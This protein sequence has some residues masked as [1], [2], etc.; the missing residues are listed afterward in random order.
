M[1][2]RILASLALLAVLPAAPTA[3]ADDDLLPRLEAEYREALKVE[4]D[5]RP[6]EQAAKLLAE[7]NNRWTHYAK[8]TALIRKHRPKAAVPLLMVYMIKHTTGPNPHII[9]PAYADTLVILTGVDFSVGRSTRPDEIGRKVGKL[10]ADWWLPGREKISTSHADMTPAQLGRV[11]DVLLARSARCVNYGHDHSAGRTA[12]GVAHNIPRI[13]KRVEPHY[14]GWMREDLCAAMTAY[15]LRRAGWRPASA[16]DPARPAAR[17]PALPYEIIPILA[18]IRRNSGADELPAVAADARQ[19]AA[20]RLAALLALKAAGEKMPTQHVLA[21]L[22]GEKD[23]VLRLVAILSL[24]H[25]TDKRAAAKKLLSLMADRNDEIRSAAVWGLRELAPPQAVPHLKT[26][27]DKLDPPGVISIALQA[28]GRIKTDKS[29]EALVAF[30]GAAAEDRAK[31]KHLYDALRA[32]HAAT[33]CPVKP[34]PHYRKPD[35]DTVLK[36]QAAQAVK[37]WR[38]CQDNEAGG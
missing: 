30:V 17:S 6:V 38:T 18:E 23:L 35:R 20:A 22:D 9:I 4:R 27:I 14:R 28:L 31:E 29:A 15:L 13:L 32:F 16:A 3:A 33:G 26:V 2:A 21:V 34:N 37:W 19:P 24:H 8:A 25:S 1:N 7:T 36:T 5:P 12:Y 11:V 10:L